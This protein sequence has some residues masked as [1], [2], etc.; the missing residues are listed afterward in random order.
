[1]TD[2][3]ALKGQLTDLLRSRGFTVNEIPR[4]DHPTADFVVNDDV[5]SYVVE[6]KLRENLPLQQDPLTV[7]VAAGGRT[8]RASGILRAAADQLAE[9]PVGSALRV[10]WVLAPE[11]DRELRYRQFEST[12]YGILIAAG[13]G[14]L[15]QCYYATHADFHR[16]QASLDGMAL[17]TFGA[18]LLNDLS[19][20]YARL[21]DSKLTRLFGTAVRDPVALEAAGEIITVRGDVDR[22]D[23]AAVVEY[24]NRVHG[25]PV[26][27]LTQLSHFSV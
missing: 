6:L 15:R 26:A 16:F 9:P 5:D 17:G 25:L 10:V 21:R 11:P 18:L 14:I 12:A 22:T 13:P 7:R 8:N 1:M 3:T 4:S 2:D 24:L 27:E 19:G 23:K 20:G